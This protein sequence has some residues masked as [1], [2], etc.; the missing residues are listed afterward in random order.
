MADVPLHGIESDHQPL[1]DHLV[2]L[3]SGQQLKHLEL[4]GGQSGNQ[5]RHD[6]AARRGAWQNRE[7]M[8]FKRMEQTI[9]MGPLAGGSRG[10]GWGG[11]QPAEW[12]S[13]RRALVEKDAKVTGRCGQAHALS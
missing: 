10:C 4:A 3:A 8:A 13:H 11:C 7:P 1:S 2:G 6:C 12:H 5:S 9:K